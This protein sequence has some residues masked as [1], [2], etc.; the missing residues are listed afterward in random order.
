MHYESAPGTARDRTAGF[1]LVELLVV[2]AIIGILVGLLLPAV[3]AAREAARR[4]QCVN[5]LKQIALGIH[6]YE[7]VHRCFPPGQMPANAASPHVLIM[8]YLEQSNTFSLFNFSFAMVGVQNNAAAQVNVPSYQCPS[9]A[10][11]GFMTHASTG[12]AGK[13]SY[14]QCLGVSTTMADNTN[15]AMFRATAA[16]RTRDVL[17]GLSNTAMFSEIKRGHGQGLTSVSTFAT[18]IALGSIQDYASPVVINGV[19]VFPIP[20]NP[21]P[22]VG[23]VYNPAQCNLT[24]T[25]QR[26]AQARGNRYFDSNCLVLFY[27]H[28]LPPNSPLR[29]CVTTLTTEG[30]MAARSYHPGG[31]NAAF[32]DG[33]VRFATDSVDAQVWIA[34]GTRAG[35]E[36]VGEW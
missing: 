36:I 29:D 13:T 21:V 30:H 3:Q 6:N 23:T 9:E 24:S 20:P 35:G 15:T 1:T 27:N 8:P 12:V 28:T 18:G 34:V 22:T 4:T 31:V 26:R 17:D 5:N 14:A 7:S 2:I 33:S 11:A 19:F 10:S 25:T 16:T 32:G